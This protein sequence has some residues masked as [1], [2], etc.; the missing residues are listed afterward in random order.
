MNVDLTAAITTFGQ[1]CSG[2]EFILSHTRVAAS[3]RHSRK[4]A[5]SRSIRHIL[6]RRRRIRTI[7]RIVP[8][9]PLGQYPQFLLYGHVGTAPSNKMM[10]ITKRMM[11]ILDPPISKLLLFPRPVESV[12]FGDTT[13]YRGRGVTLSRCHTSFDAEQAS[14]T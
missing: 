7:K 8:I 9:P 10:R 12:P 14:A 5:K 6:P 11:P 4:R 2:K 13:W 1:S 3:A